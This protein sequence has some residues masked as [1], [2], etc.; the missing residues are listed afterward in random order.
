MIK[1]CKLFLFFFLC[2]LFFSINV[3][4]TLDSTK[5]YS[6]VIKNGQIYD[7]SGNPPFKGMIVIDHD[8][9]AYVGPS[10]Q[11]QAE[12]TIDATNLVVSPGFI[13]MLSWAT[14]SLL[15]DGRSEGNLRQGVTLEVF[16]EGRSMGPLN[17]AMKRTLKKSQSPKWVTYDVN[18][19][20]L[21]EFL[22]H[23][24]KK[25]IS[26][27]VA[28]FVGAT[29]LRIHEVGHTHAPPTKRQLH[30]MKH[31]LHKEMKAGAL[32]LGSALEYI[33]GLYATQH[34]LTE[35]AKVVS[36]YDGLYISHLRNE[37]PFLLDALD[38]FIAIAKDASVRSDIY[39]LKA[40]GKSNYY[41]LD[42]A[43]E[44]IYT[45]RLKQI[46]IGANM[47]TY[48][49]SSTSLTQLL[50]RWVKKGSFSE[51]IT[52]L[53]EAQHRDTIKSFIDIQAKQ[54]EG[55]YDG[56][57]IAGLGHS[58]LFHKLGKSIKELS[59]QGNISPADVVIDLII[60]DRSKIQVVYFSMSEDNIIKK[61]QLPYIS[62][63]S[64]S[65]SYPI[66]KPFTNY[67]THPRA[68]GNFSRLLSKYVREDNVLSME[69]AIY[70]LTF[71]AASRL[72]IQRRGLLKAGYYA[73][74][75]IFNPET[76]QDHATFKTPHR[77]ATGMNYVFVNGI[78]TII[79]DKHTE[80][81][82]G[83]FVKGPGYITP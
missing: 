28:S 51:W 50:P 39:H 46:D 18:W 25:G 42:L 26:T 34:E 2:S 19:T 61:L 56:I 33:P 16:G 55:G 44:K 27:N 10:I 65:G 80:K 13:N 29:T 23:L 12:Q 38:E 71:L 72:K 11:V 60:E 68:Y 73:D 31:L 45:A 5:V 75:V 63:G 37:G 49:A 58:T 20:S 35:L 21:S 59:V 81:F 54:F 30:R 9:I 8:S 78:A 36:R 4:N 14:E 32:G 66:K 76:I 47:Y 62:F 77:Y 74:V 6:V 83:R 17:S 41:K 15:Y 48:N 52:R 40:H 64:D 79:N 1:P 53:K 57:I 67:K 22:T 7:G 70:K 82:P 24:E 3:A 43:I 69:E